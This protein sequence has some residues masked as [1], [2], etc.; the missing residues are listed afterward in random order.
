M[1]VALV[2][3]SVFGIEIATRRTVMNANPASQPPTPGLDAQYA[4]LMET[5]WACEAQWTLDDKL[6][7]AIRYARRDNEH[8]DD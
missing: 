6:D 7:A 3:D 8:K 4:E 2:A 5:V 1:S